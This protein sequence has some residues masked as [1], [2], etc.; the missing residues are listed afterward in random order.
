MK[1]YEFNARSI[2]TEFINLYFLKNNMTS[3]TYMRELNKKKIKFL[4]IQGRKKRWCS[5][6]D[7]DDFNRQRFIIFKMLH[8]TFHIFVDDDKREGER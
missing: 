8:L 4:L 3:C 5:T 7:V 6:S 1:F 2:F